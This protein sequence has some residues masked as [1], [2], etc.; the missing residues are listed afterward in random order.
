M[1]FCYPIWYRLKPAFRKKEEGTYPML[2]PSKGQ[3]K[4]SSPESTFLVPSS[5]CVY[6]VCSLWLVYRGLLVHTTSRTSLNIYFRFSTLC[7]WGNYLIITLIH[8]TLYSF[9]IFI[10][11]LFSLSFYLDQSCKDFFPFYFVNIFKELIWEL[12]YPLF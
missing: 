6:L 12:I 1:S 8:W 10:P 9:D 11:N 5:S 4:I 2:L 3:S 7:H